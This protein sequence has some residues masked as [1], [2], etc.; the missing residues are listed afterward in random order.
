M[1]Y[2]A[3]EILNVLLTTYIQSLKQGYEGTGTETCHWVS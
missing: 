1:D 2:E 3:K